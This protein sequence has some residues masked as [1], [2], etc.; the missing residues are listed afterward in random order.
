M[1]KKDC[2]LYL[3]LAELARSNVSG[4][5][6]REMIAAAQKRLVRR[7]QDTGIVSDEEA[8]ALRS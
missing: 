6:R 3:E 4:P 2:D 7:L 8:D 5:V 1:T